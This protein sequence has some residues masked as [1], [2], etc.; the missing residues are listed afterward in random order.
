LY[1]DSD[2]VL[3]A[4]T[5]ETM[6]ADLTTRGY[7]AI[8]ARVLRDVVIRTKAPGEVTATIPMFCTL[9]PRRLILKYGFDPAMPDCDDFEISYQL[10]KDGHKIA[11]S[12]AY[13]H[14]KVKDLKTSTKHI[15][16]CGMALAEFLLKYKKSPPIVFKYVIFRGLGSLVHEIL[17]CIVK[18]ELKFIPRLLLLGLFEI[19]GF[20]MKLLNTLL[21]TTK[22]IRR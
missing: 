6:L 17:L 16:R 13:A 10:Q 11:V 2:V 14:H 20:T 21:V 19:A 18:G 5:L 12:S 1:V 15:Y 8:C 7:A 3:L 9:F 4:N 22:L